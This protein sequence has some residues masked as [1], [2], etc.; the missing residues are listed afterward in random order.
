M[1]MPVRMAAVAC[2][3]IGLRI[4]PLGYADSYPRQPGVDARHYVFRIA[5]TDTSDEIFGETTVE[6]RFVQDGVG[7]FTLDLASAANGKG[8]RVTEV[9]M[10]DAPA[11]YAHQGDRLTIE[12]APAPKAGELREFTVKY[13]GIPAG[14]LRIGKNRYGERAFFSNNWPDRAR[15]W[16][17]TIDHPY[18]KA[19]SEFIVTAPAQYQVVA[20]GRLEE[21]IDL[22]GGRRVT[23][24]KESVPIASWLNNIGVARFAARYFGAAAGIPL[25][26]WVF[27][28]DRQAGMAAF[29]EPTRQAMEFFS[30]RIGA[31]P[32]EKLAA[33]EAAGTDG[34]ME[35]ASAI[36]YGEKTLHPENNCEG[37]Q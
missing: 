32:Y 18:D 20:N 28:Q 6:A 8:M 5:L 12:V 27:Y 16:L 13:R 1:R 25:E 4:T 26:T 34:G 9:R 37:R 24:W 10:G 23:H 3:L 30:E 15:Q 17:P 11:R 7:E 31:Y 35:N 33:V 19:T 2:A 22:A 29:E 21:Q 14:G 36:F